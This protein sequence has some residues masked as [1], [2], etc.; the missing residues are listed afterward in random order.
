MTLSVRPAGIEDID[1]ICEIAEAAWHEAHAPIIGT[2]TVEEFLEEYYESDSFRTLVHDESIILA[3]AVADGSLGG[4][5]SVRSNEEST[6]TYN[7]NRLYVHP[8]MW[9]NGIG[10]RLV[11]YAEES[12]ADRGGE[13]IELWVM[14]ANDRA[15]DFYEAAGY[16]R[17]EQIYDETIETE[18]LVYAKE[19]A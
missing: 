18:S 2:E 12:V 6:A 13:R 5:I 17:E 14:A 4:F 16:T 11:E 10:Q 8:E 9:G 15:I 1:R 3:V 19:I 7:L